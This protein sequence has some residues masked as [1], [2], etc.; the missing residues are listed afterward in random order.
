MTCSV[1]GSSG[2]PAT[3]SAATAP[4]AYGYDGDN[5]LL[6]L[7][8]SNALSVRRLYGGGS[9][10]V[11]SRESAA[12]ALT[13]YLS[14]YQ[15]SVIGL[16]AAAGGL[17]GVTSYDGFG[18]IQSDTTGALGDRY[19]WTGREMDFATGEQ[20][21]RARYYDPALGKWTTQDPEGFAAGDWDLYRYV[22]NNATDA[23]DPSGMYFIAVGN[24]NATAWEA[25]LEKDHGL[26]RER[27]LWETIAVL[28]VCFAPSR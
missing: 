27:S 2:T 21:N 16:A 8:G 10:E 14:D 6:D 11:L 15:G 13:W 24:A 19:R 22:G 20:F 5:V 28:C 26:N 9:D 4:S 12:G 18:N 1:G 23:V 3:S 17:I 25:S 7:T